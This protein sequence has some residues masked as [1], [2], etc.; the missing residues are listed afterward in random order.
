MS[1][2]FPGCRGWNGGH[3]EDL[4]DPPRVLYEVEGYPGFQLEAIQARYGFYC[5]SYVTPDHL[6]APQTFVIEHEAIDGPP[7]I[8]HVG[9]LALYDLTQ[10]YLTERFMSVTGRARVQLKDD[11]HPY[12]A[13][14]A[15]WNQ[16]RPFEPKLANNEPG[17][18]IAATDPL[19]KVWQAIQPTIEAMRLQGG[20]RPI[21]TGRI[22]STQHFLELVGGEI[23]WCLNR[24]PPLRPTQARIGGRLRREHG[25][26]IKKGREAETM[27][28]WR[29]RWCPGTSW[30]RIVAEAQRMS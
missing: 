12:L 14:V 22:H 28:E 16:G 20:G 18:P 26:P 8:I 17:L 9:T 30:E 1:G 11:L 21:G 15:G 24:N 5:L 4:T 27:Q 7:E 25:I 10:P 13:L 3:T 23:R 2:A 29:Q 6:R 19:R